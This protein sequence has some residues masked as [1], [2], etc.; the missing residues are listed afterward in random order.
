VIE[1]DDEEDTGPVRLWPAVLALGVAA[2]L[3]VTVAIV[4]LSAGDQRDAGAPE[5]PRTVRI[6]LVLPVAGDRVRIVTVGNACRETT[7]AT[8]DLRADGI[9]FQV[10][11]RS[12]REAGAE[13]ADGGPACAPDVAACHEV[14]LPQ[15][16]G[17]RR[18]LP[19]PVADAELRAQA[20]RLAADGPCD[21]LPLASG[22]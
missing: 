9:A 14:T 6:L 4:V 1:D 2:V 21:P 11:A 18:L 13:D 3:A 22:T 12:G 17:P 20:E 5:D 16:V 7:G 8:A 10:L 19:S 15:A